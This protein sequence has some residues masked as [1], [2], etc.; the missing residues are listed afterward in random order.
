V[1]ALLPGVWCALSPVSEVTRVC[2]NRDY[3]L[4]ERARTLV[5][6]GTYPAGG[7]AAAPHERPA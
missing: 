5:I 2:G 3:R 1:Y 7:A 6:K 4:L